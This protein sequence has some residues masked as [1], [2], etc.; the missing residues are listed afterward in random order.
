MVNEND[1]SKTNYL[2]STINAA[3]C[4]ASSVSDY[5]GL[6]ARFASAPFAIPTYFR[7]VMEDKLSIA[8]EGDGF[9]IYAKVN[10]R[11]ISEIIATPAAMTSFLGVGLGG[12]AAYQYNP[13]L[14]LVPALTNAAS[15]LYELSRFVAKKRQGK[16]LEKMINE[17]MDE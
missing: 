5:V 15:G 12:T 10:N 4:I 1:A 2:A 11:E 3:A 7:L 9:G 17:L 6:T 16:G 14:L 8:S 13:L